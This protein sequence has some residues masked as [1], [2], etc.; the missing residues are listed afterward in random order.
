MIALRFSTD[1]E[2]ELQAAGFREAYVYVKVGE[3]NMYLIKQRARRI[4]QYVTTIFHEDGKGVRPIAI[5]LS[6]GEGQGDIFEQMGFFRWR[7]LGKYISS[8]NNSDDADEVENR[9]FFEGMK[10]PPIAWCVGSWWGRGPD[11]CT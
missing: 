11:G 6:Y 1:C 8:G 2:L 5:I 7:I 10:N 4:N 3:Q 9:K